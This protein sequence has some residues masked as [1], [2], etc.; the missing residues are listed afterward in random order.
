MRRKILSVAAIACM[1]AVVFPVSATIP[2]TVDAQIFGYSP[3]LFVASRP[4]SFT[5]RALDVPH[6]FSTD[7][8]I[9]E[10]PFGAL[11][12]CETVAFPGGP[13]TVKIHQDAPTGL[14]PFF[15]RIHPGMRGNVL[16]AL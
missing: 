5:F 9:C 3:S 7:V 8:A 12:P 6:T 4:D 16:I 14:V 11:A 15:C 13:V 1:M 2:G 10:D